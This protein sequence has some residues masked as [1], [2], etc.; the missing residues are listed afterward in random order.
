MPRLLI[1]VNQEWIERL[2]AVIPSAISTLQG[3]ELQISSARQEGEFEAI[4][5]LDQ[6][7]SQLA[8]LRRNLQS[9]RIIF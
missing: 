5:L 4:D 9:V 3:L 6:I 7:A 2:Q 8:D 1:N